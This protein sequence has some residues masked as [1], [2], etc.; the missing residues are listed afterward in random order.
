VSLGKTFSGFSACQSSN[1][2]VQFRPWTSKLVSA[3]R[4]LRGH[5]QRDVHVPVYTRAHMLLTSRAMPL[6]PLR[7]VTAKLHVGSSFV[8]CLRGKS[9][10][11]H[12]AIEICEPSG[13]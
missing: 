6:L 7:V 9:I 2:K 1:D 11:S 13:K 12:R 8:S 5:S 10:V 4:S 3:C